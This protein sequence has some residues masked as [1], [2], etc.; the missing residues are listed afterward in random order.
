MEIQAF[1][2][3]DLKVKE[4][5]VNAVI[6]LLNEGATVPFIARYR[7]EMTGGLN[8]DQ[9]R[10]L[11]DK[12]IYLTDVSARQQ[13]ILNSI[14]EQGKLTPDLKKTILNTLN[15]T[16]LEDLYLPYK[17]KRRTKAEIAKEAGILPFA[18]KILADPNC[19]LE[20]VAST[21]LNV[22]KGFESTKKVLEGAQ[23]ILAEQFSEQA[24]LLKK[25]REIFCKNAVIKSEVVDENSDKAAKFS[26]YFEFQESVQSIP[27]HRILA[28][29][30]GRKEGVLR[31]KIDFPSELFIENCTRE[32]AQF[33]EIPIGLSA[34]NWLMKTVLWTWKIK[35]HTK[36][37]LEVMVDLK[38]RAD[39]ESIKVFAN[40]LKNLLMAA[41]AGNH[42]VLGLDPGYRTGVKT[43]V[44]DGT[45]KLLTYT[46]IYPHAP[47]KKWHDAL[48]T[49]E[50][51][52]E[53]FQVSLI[54]IGNGT[55]SRETD[56]L[57]S[58]LIAKNKKLKMSKIVVSE[59]GASVYSASALASK[60]FPD[61]D[62]SFRGAV[63]IARRLQDPLAELVKIDPKSIGVGQ[64]Q[65][66]VN[67]IKLGQTL[68]ATVEDCV[69]AVGADL[70][71]AS[72]PLLSSISGLNE[73]IAQQIVNYREQHGRF[74]TRQDLMKVSRFGEKTFEQSAGF[75]RINN[76]E[77]ILDASAVHPESYAI[78]KDISDKVKK[79]INDLIGNH[80]LINTLDPKT[81]VTEGT[82]LPTIQDIFKELQKPGRDPRPSFQMAE[83]T[84]GVNEMSD[85]QPGMQLEGVVTNVANFGAFVDIGVHQDGL[86]HVSQLANYFVKDVHKEVA[87]G[88]IVKVRV[89]EVDERK[90]RISLTMKDEGQQVPK[91]KKR[92][93]RNNDSAKESLLGDKLK[94][95][96]NQ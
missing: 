26:D 71:T 76:G 38:S 19:D 70:N 81:Y 64:Y 50:K 95:A 22:E 16:E 36:L 85:L 83:F 74:K 59:A 87:V 77:N 15:K 31:L 9:L 6:K 18:E 88:Q 51:L 23:Y 46:V 80:E 73:S 86:V 89:L 61:L 55:A 12:F 43:V 48:H 11:H 67:Q 62:V 75:L 37:E 40:N 78:V 29:M 41:P 7:K 24:D 90:K 17:P 44:V 32:I 34:D 21:Y 94:A 53:K 79:P 54:S 49:L 56:Q 30:R 69:N 3:K 93:Q 4:A 28:I 1:I 60:E 47:Q 84:E 14:E 39:E 13:V 20:Q 63:S 72:V 25:L 8:D 66:D 82:G 5:Q 10:E 2:A 35:L 91:S 96:L 58:E 27:G 45:G 68:T 33:F 65:H 42:V 92:S 57:A 52:C